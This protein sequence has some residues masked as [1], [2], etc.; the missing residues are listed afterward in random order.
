[1]SYVIVTHIFNLSSQEA[2]AGRALEVKS[3]L[4]YV[5]NSLPAM[6]T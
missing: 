4:V 2:E 3:I 5:E 1:M 6:A